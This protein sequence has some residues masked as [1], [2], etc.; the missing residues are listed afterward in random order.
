MTGRDA[1]LKD[2]RIPLEKGR[3]RGWGKVSIPADANPAD[4]AYWFAFDRPKPRLAVVVAEDPDAARPLQLAASIA[5]DPALKCSAEVIGVEQLTG[6]RVG[7]ARAAALAGAAPRGRAGQAG[8]VVRRSRRPGDLLPAQG[9]DRR[10]V[11]RRPLESTGPR[12]QQGRPGRW[13]ARRPGSARPDP[14]RVAAAGRAAR[15]P[16]VLPAWRGSRPRWRPSKE[17]PRS[18]PGSRPAEAASTSARPPRAEG[19]SSLAS[20]GRRPLCPGP[21]GPRRR[22]VGPRRH[23]AARGG[24]PAGRRPAGT[25]SGWRARRRPLDRLR[26]RSRASMRRATACSR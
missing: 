21:A 11:P 15:G 2:H 4:D 7:E 6:G 18:W 23:P 19:D 25:G 17:A 22:R 8:Q 13:L 24:R 1:E 26:R 10:G 14:E 12:A 20:G 3:A 5:P 16:A 9:P